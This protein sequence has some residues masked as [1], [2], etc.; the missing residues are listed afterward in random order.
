M[1]GLQLYWKRVSGTSVFLWILRNFE[2]HLFLQSTSGGFFW[3]EKRENSSL[4][5]YK[6][7]KDL[8]PFLMTLIRQIIS[9]SLLQIILHLRR[10]KNVESSAYIVYKKVWL[11]P[12][13]FLFFSIDRIIISRTIL[14]LHAFWLY[15]T[16]RFL[17]FQ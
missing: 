13:I 6:K 14:G 4:N 8:F 2:E 11:H 17:I 1:P 3:P 5:C 12:L 16:Q 7:R 15:L 9:S 10:L